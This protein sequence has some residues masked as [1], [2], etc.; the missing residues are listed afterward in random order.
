MK[1][2]KKTFQT[3]PKPEKIDGKGSKS[4]DNNSNLINKKSVEHT[5]Y[6]TLE[7]QTIPKTD[8]LFIKKNPDLCF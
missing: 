2:V 5:K 1:V 4:S 7:K 8:L 3:L 6:R